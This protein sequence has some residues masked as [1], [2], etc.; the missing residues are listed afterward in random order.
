MQKNKWFARRSDKPGFRIGTA[1]G[2][3][4]LLL[5]GILLL[6]IS[7]ADNVKEKELLSNILFFVGQTCIQAAILSVILELH[8]IQE[9]YQKVRDYLLLEEPSFLERYTE[10]EVDRIIELGIKQKIR[11][12]ARRPLDKTIFDPLLAKNSFL[13]EP[14]IEHT[15]NHLGNNGFYCTYHRRQINIFPISNTEYKI[16]VTVE[17]ELQ[18]ITAEPVEC[19]QEYKFYYI[20]QKQIDSFRLKSCEIDGKDSPIEPEDL[21]KFDDNRPSTSRHPFN[22]FVQFSVPLKIE[23]G[24]QS[25]YTLNYE[26]SNYEQ[27]CYI[28]YSLPFLTKSFQETYSLI[29]ENAYEYQIHASAYTPYKQQIDH[30]SLVQRLNDVTLSINSNK[31]IVPGSGFVAVVRKKCGEEGKNPEKEPENASEGA[32]KE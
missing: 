26:Y 23:A 12:K 24:K 21:K 15:A 7:N 22:F 1:A 18:N 30:R 11:L 17:L 20:S 28:T 6:L 19:M 29:G 27:S 8:S 4:L 16:Y 13:L 14:Y 2:L 5:F 3:V 10:E 32:D 9:N 25:H 31:W